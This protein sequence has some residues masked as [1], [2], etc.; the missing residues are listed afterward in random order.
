M[1]VSKLG[2]GSSRIRNDYIIASFGLQSEKDNCTNQLSRNFL[3]L[4][5]PCMDFAI[6]FLHFPV[7]LK[8]E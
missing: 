7:I 4:R 5:A 6:C 8:T 1:G 3:M 2:E